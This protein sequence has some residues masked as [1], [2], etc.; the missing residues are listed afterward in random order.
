MSRLRSKIAA[1]CATSTVAFAGVTALGVPAL[2]QETT[3]ETSPAE[4]TSETA[5]A[6]S[7][8]A[9]DGTMTVEKE[10]GDQVKVN[11]RLI[12]PN[13]QVDLHIRKII[14]DPTG[15]DTPA[16]DAKP[17]VG[18]TFNVQRIKGID[19]TTQAGWAKVSALAK[20][21]D[22][23]RSLL[24]D[25]KAG[26]KL[27]DSAFADLE[28]GEAKDVTTDSNGE[29]TASF[30]GQGAFVVTEKQSN[31]Y[32]VA[33]P[34][35]VTLPYP[36]DD[37]QWA[38][39]RTV[40]PKNQNV[41]PTKD[42]D[43]NDK[44]LGQ[45][46]RYTINAPV[47][48]GVIDRFNVVDPVDSEHLK[49]QNDNIEVTTTSEDVQLTRD[50]DY[51]VS[52]ED[53]TLRV[54]FT[55]AG[56][57]KLQDA[58][59]DHPDFAVK[60]SFD[61]QVIKIPEADGKINNTGEIELPNGATVDTDTQDEDGKDQPTQATFGDLTVTKTSAD[62]EDKP[63]A[64]AGAE[65]EVYRCE[66]QGE[67]KWETVGEAIEVSPDGTVNLENHL[68]TAV[69][70][71]DADEDAAMATAH[72]LPVTTHGGVNGTESIDY[73]VIETKAPE[74]FV[75]NPEVHHATVQ[76]DNI[77]KLAVSVE[78]QRSNFLNQ[79]PATGAWGIVLVFLLGLGLLARGL[80]TSRR[81]RQTA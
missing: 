38:Y 19:L 43:A 75:R 69:G 63:D 1:L 49:L 21:T 22:D 11:P 16:D 24:S 57:K 27:T 70:K 15:G 65:F 62:A 36:A 28:L 26:K 2:A 42:V 72:G 76:G 40:Y 59:K 12:D 14:G 73:C 4:T 52:T 68:T 3:S 20:A 61:A 58:R 79:L 25:W 80:Y 81:D 8:A 66:Q 34:F 64:L 39:E 13:K 47:P 23:N 74:G 51:T 48:A 6:E 31:G 77:R 44:G 7:E 35:I 71:N 9:G 50:T 17:G 55:D 10:D 60:V 45:N 32:T 78:N 54:N 37:G 46:L 5:P 29:A 18:I 53:N 67:N 41:V 56:R 30:D 33:Q